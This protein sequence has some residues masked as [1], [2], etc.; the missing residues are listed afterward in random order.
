MR[1]PKGACYEKCRRREIFV[2]V[3]ADNLRDWHNVL[4][5][6]EVAIVC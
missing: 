3:T 2:R 6:E 4:I 1:L 5:A